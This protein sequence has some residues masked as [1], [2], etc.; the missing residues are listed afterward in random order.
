MQATSN[1]PSAIKIKV[2]FTLLALEKAFIYY[3]H[4]A[5]SYNIEAF[6][7]SCK[8]Q[9]YDARVSYT[10]LAEQPGGKVGW[11]DLGQV[12]DPSYHLADGAIVYL[13]PQMLGD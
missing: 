13:L 9:S 1:S 7:L 11:L 5:L 10:F 2:R 3:T 4:E 6:L 12:I 8:L